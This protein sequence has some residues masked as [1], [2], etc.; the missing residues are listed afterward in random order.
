MRDGEILEQLALA[1]ERA[2][3]RRQL[4]ARAGL[5]VGALTAG[6]WLAACGSGN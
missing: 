5:G 6:G 3:T 2:V 1:G 4:V